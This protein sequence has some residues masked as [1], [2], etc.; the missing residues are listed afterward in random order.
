M[1]NEK[2]TGAFGDGA[3]AGMFD[4]QAQQGEYEYAK[5]HG[6]TI[7]WVGYDPTVRSSA[8]FP[9]ASVGGEVVAAEASNPRLSSGASSAA[10]PFAF[11]KADAD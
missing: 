6:C 11:E 8:V 7:T 2:S 10:A 1:Y 4:G 9:V 5:K 3:L